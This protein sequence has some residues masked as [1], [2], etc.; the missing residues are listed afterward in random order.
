MPYELAALAA[1][2][3]WVFASLIAADAS[4][5]IGG[6]AFNRL[7]LSTGFVMLLVLTLGTGTLIEIP[8]QHFPV[9]ALSGLIGLGIGDTAL[10]AAFKRLGPRRAQILY[11]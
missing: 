4:R 5:E 3:S 6:M 1:A 10:F 7:R 2:L 9:L 8:A 11:A